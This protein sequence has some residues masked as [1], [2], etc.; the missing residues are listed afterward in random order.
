MEIVDINKQEVTFRLTIAET[1]RLSDALDAARRAQ[2]HVEGDFWREWRKQVKSMIATAESALA[3]MRGEEPLRAGK[4]ADDYRDGYGAGVAD[5]FFAVQSDP[6][7]AK[8]VVGEEP[9]RA[10]V[11]AQALRGMA[12]VLRKLSDMLTDISQGDL[13]DGAHA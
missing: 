6:T 7:F 2:K 8:E 4:A 3:Q 9:L 13:A 10:A 1:A 12:G 11:S 5:T